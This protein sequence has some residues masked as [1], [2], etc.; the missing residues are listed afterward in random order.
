MASS[1]ERKQRAARATEA[2]LLAVATL[3]F[4]AFVVVSA[5]AANPNADEYGFKNSTGDISDE[6]VTQVQNCQNAES[7]HH[8]AACPDN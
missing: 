6:F 8:I 2:G 4:M 1:K 7:A 5:F 3:T